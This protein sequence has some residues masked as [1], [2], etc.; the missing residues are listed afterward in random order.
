M[1]KEKASQASQEEVDPR[2][3]RERPCRR[4][5]SKLNCCERLSPAAQ[6]TGRALRTRLG[7]SASPRLWQCRPGAGATGGVQLSVPGA[8]RVWGTGPKP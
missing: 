7:Q 8:A 6:E 2:E 4:K 5:K 3:V 1:T